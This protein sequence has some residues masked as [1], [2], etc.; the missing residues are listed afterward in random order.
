MNVKVNETSFIVP[1]HWF[2]EEFN[3][4]GWEP[5]TYKIMNQYLRQ[6]KGYLDIGTW[7]GPT[8]LYALE[9]GVDKIYGIE[10]NPF[11]FDLAKTL[12]IYN[13]VREEY[14]NLYN[15]CVHKESDM[16]IPFGPTNGN[17]TSSASSTRGTHWKIR[18]TT[19]MDWIT[20]NKIVNYNFIKIDIEGSEENICPDLKELSKQKDLVILLSLHP[21]FFTDLWKGTLC[22]VSTCSLFDIYDSNHIPLER[23]EL[24]K[25]LLSLDK[26]PPWGTK[27]GNYF[28]VILKTKS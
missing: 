6:D 23:K 17:W 12:C 3:Q 27:L 22:L 18:S 25:R 13:G 7:V 11:S 4:T 5:S 14:V 20:K 21:D 24:T 2:W 15:L 26:T 10:A 19:L 8:L 1:Q 9:I 28:E 16:I